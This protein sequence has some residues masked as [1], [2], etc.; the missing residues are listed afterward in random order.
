MDRHYGITCPT[1]TPFRAATTIQD[2]VLRGATRAIE[3][4]AEL[5][6]SSQRNNPPASILTPDKRQTRDNLIDT[7][8]TK[9]GSAAMTM[10]PMGETSEM[11]AGAGDCR[12]EA[13]RRMTAEQL[14]HL[15]K[16]QV[17]YLKVGMRDGELAFVVY[18][19][20]G[21]ALMIVDAVEAAVEMAVEHG[22]G[23]VTVH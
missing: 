4:R 6:A 14:L 5:F 1:R 7:V 18:G 3:K 9:G 17:A 10:H 12:T 11:T 8:A 2:V 15:G 23:F 13:L 20:D 16:R 19:A 21:T 22:L